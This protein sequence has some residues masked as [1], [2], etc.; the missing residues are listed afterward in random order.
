MLMRMHVLILKCWV[1]E[2]AMIQVSGNYTM[3]RIHSPHKGKDGKS[4]KN[5]VDLEKADFHK[6]RLLIR[7]IS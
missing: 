1:Q 2:I 7:R 4:K 5:I 3:M 6:I